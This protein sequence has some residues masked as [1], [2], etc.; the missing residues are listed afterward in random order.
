MKRIPIPNRTGPFRDSRKFGFTLLEILITLGILSVMTVLIATAIQNALRAK[1]SLQGQIDDVSRIRDALRMIQGDLHLAFHY[2]DIEKEIQDLAKKNSQNSN[3]GTN[4]NQPSLPQPNPTPQPFGSG[5]QREVPR[6]DPETHFIGAT[7]RMDFVTLNNGRMLKDT[8][9]SDF[10]EVGYS[11][12]DCKSLSE[13]RKNSKCLWRRTSNTVDDDVTKG[14]EEIVLI[15]D[16][17]EFKMRY[18]G[19]GKQDWNSEWRTDKGG[20]GATKGRFPLAIEVSLIVMK[21]QKKG[22]DKKYSF[23]YVIP[24]HFPNNPVDEKSSSTNPNSGTSSGGGQ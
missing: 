22:K 2:R 5:T 14:G 8:R 4:P 23:Q 19:K 10:V 12:K 21:P 18:F 11:L 16:V 1:V 3:Q 7:E 20:D 13:D 17:S 9:Q 24:I 15:E 6:Q